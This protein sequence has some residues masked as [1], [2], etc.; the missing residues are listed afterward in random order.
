M[1]TASQHRSSGT[2]TASTSA[3]VETLEGRRLFAAQT[4]FFEN[5][6]GGGAGWSEV[7][8]LGQRTRT[9]LGAAVPA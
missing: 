1:N 3:V 8:P 9:D 6:E 5:F 2:D 4:L 7:E